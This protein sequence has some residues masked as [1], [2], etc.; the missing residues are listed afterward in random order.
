MVAHWGGRR[1]ASRRERKM[2]GVGHVTVT[3][4]EQVGDK[5]DNHTEGSRSYS[6]NTFTYPYK[7]FL[8]THTSKNFNTF[9]LNGN[10]SKIFIQ[11]WVT[12]NIVHS[13]LKYFL[14]PY[15]NFPTSSL[16][17]TFNNVSS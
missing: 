6:Y 12:S 4:V 8:V 15:L 17:H 11:N 1:G 10:L 13:P 5:K 3:V 2:G 14:S 16:N 7:S 9:R